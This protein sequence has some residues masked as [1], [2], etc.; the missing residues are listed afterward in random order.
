MGVPMVCIHGGTAGG[1]ASCACTAFAAR[2]VTVAPTIPAPRARKSRRPDLLD[3]LLRPMFPPSGIMQRGHHTP[4]GNTRAARPVDATSPG[5]RLG[6]GLAAYW[7]R[8]RQK[9]DFMKRFGIIAAAALALA[10]AGPAG[11]LEVGEKAPDF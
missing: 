8:F 5:G 11:A 1:A 2:P 10:L 9:E 4:D 7:P 3:W 6:P